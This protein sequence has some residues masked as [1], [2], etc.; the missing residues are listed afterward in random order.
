MSTP[1]NA[2]EIAALLDELV[3][4]WK[5]LEGGLHPP[6]SREQIQAF[7]SRYG[8]RL[9]DDLSRYFLSLDGME[10]GCYDDEFIRFWRLEELRPAADVWGPSTP[11]YF[12]L[13]DWSIDAH[14]YAIR[15]GSDERH[16]V[17]ILGGK[18]LTQVAESF[19][20]FLWK[21]LKQPDALF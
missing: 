3:Q 13:A 14:A 10:D 11:D 20:D 18:E 19:T 21:Y 8:V 16:P 7:E 15:L 6:S 1:S 12:V 9:P 5:T 2:S 17:A 4:R